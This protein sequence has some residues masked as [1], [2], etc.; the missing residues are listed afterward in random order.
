MQP[1]TKTKTR[2]KAHKKNKPSSSN[3][4]NVLASGVVQLGGSSSPSEILP[5]DIFF[6]PSDNFAIS[7]MLLGKWVRFF[8]SNSSFLIGLM[9]L[10]NNSH[11]LRRILIDKSVMILGD[12]FIVTESEQTP[13]LKSL[14]K[15]VRFLGI[16][17]K[18]INAI[19]KLLEVVNLYGESMEE[20][21]YKCAFDFNA[22]GNCIV[23]L[24]KG[25]KDGQKKLM[26]YHKELHKTAIHKKNDKG[27][28]EKYGFCENWEM[29]TSKPN[30]AAD[31]DEYSVYPN[32]EKWEDGT[33]R[34]VIHIKE[35]AA[36]FFYWGVSEWI[37][38]RAWGE[39]EYRIPRYNN[40]KFKNG[41]T[42]SAIVQFFGSVTKDEAEQTVK[43]FNKK[44][45]NTG[46]NS[47]IFV[48]VLRDERLK[49]NVQV[50]EDKNDGNYLELSRVAAQA[51]V[52]ANR[53]TMSLAG[54]ATS[55]KLGTNQQMRDE[56]EFVTNICIKPKRR[57]LVNKV[58]N[59]FLKE[60][61]DYEELGIGNTRLEIANL[62]PISFASEIDVNANLLIN[63]KRNA[64]G[65][66]SL[67]LEAKQLLKAEQNT[68]EDVD[69]TNTNT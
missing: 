8:D 50:I 62:N 59:V 57:L 41:Y 56:I 51:L 39:L 5:E 34:C 12:G 1:K 22:F 11:T 49:A 60:A 24:V 21:L 4:P 66:E 2:K 52:T 45:T 63:E 25:K 37:A 53:W 35:Y 7:D 68:K 54:F 13:I 65:Y 36:G 3:K 46:N 6:E 31:I 16:E 61:D 69:T 10:V 44:F 32:F 9:E 17:D 19:N 38:A 15:L 67:S 26:I 58:L 55:G 18:K 40:S 20:V 29:Y 48:Q 28:V 43:N 14:R 42:P 27:L 23:E 30:S 47:K 33:E 64:I